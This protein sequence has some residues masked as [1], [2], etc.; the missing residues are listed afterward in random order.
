[1][2]GQPPFGH[3]LDLMVAI[4]NRCAQLEAQLELCFCAILLSKENVVL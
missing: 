1:M 2:K 3:I 4:E